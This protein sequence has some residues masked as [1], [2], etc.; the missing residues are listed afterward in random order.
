MTPNF[1]RDQMAPASVDFYTWT[2]ISIHIHTKI[3][4]IKN[5]NLK[6]KDTQILTLL[7]ASELDLTAL[8][9]L[10]EIFQLSVQLGDLRGTQMSDD[11]QT[12]C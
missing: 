8:V 5:I 3:H 6:K 2:H 9:E 11:C 4:I 1:Q 10:T 7:V 12:D